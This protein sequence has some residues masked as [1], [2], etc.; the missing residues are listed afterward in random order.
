MKI[1]LTQDIERLGKKGDIKEVADGYARN[2]LFT[3]NLAK[4]ATESTIKD[5]GKERLQVEKRKSDEIGRFE[6]LAKNLTG[7]EI[8]F[9]VALGESGRAF[10]SI[11]ANDIADELKK[12]KLVI[13]KEWI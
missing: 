2:F 11:S 5:V 8:T 13:N 6:Q 7:K 3:R 9:S 1:I 4:P 10:G 12:L